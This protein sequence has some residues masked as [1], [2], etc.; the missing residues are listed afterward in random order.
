M[1]HVI[2]IYTIVF[3]TIVFL[4]CKKSDNTPITP[5][6]VLSSVTTASGILGGPKNTLI[7]LNGSNFITDLS[8]IVVTVNGKVCE[9]LTATSTTIVAKIPAYCGTGKVV[10]SLNGIIL[11]GPVFNYVYTYSLISITNGAIGYADGAIATAK[12]DEISGLC[13]DTANNIFTSQYDKPVVRKITSDLSTVSTLAGDR[14]VGDVNGQ[15]TS[16]KLGK[17]DNIS[18]DKNGNIYYADVSSNKIKKI[19]KLG[20]VTTFISDVT[21]GFLPIAAEIGNLGNLYVLGIGFGSKSVIAKFNSSGILQWRIV[22]HGS[23]S[24]DGDSSVVKFNEITFGN[25]TIDENESNLYFATNIYATLNTTPSQIKKL[26]LTTLVT[27]TIAGLETVYGSIDGPAASATFNLVTGMAIDKL[28]G[29]YISDG[30]NNKIRLLKNGT[31]STIVGASG[32]GDVDGDLTVAKITYPDGLRFN[33]K[34]DLILAC[35]GNTKIKRLII[36]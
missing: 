20:N 23:G 31:V 12:W 21:L 3:C 28:G 33:N 36:D 27:T 25:A 17:A 8:K 1:K 14:T 10:L 34:G 4:S 32:S 22:S 6:A 26:N 13:V 2:Q 30:S 16:A 29:L 11:N 5:D 19:D 35:V 15:G 9:L 7:T 18:I 24:V